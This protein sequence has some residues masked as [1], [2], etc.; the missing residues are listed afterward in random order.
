MPTCSTEIETSTHSGTVGPS[1]NPRLTPL[2]LAKSPKLC[3]RWIILK[4]KTLSHEWRIPLVDSAEKP[5]TNN[6]TPNQQRRRLSL[7]PNLAMSTNLERLPDESKMKVIK[8]LGC[9]SISTRTPQSNPGES[10]IHLASNDNKHVENGAKLETPASTGEKE[11]LRMEGS[12]IF[13][14]S[15]ACSLENLLNVTLFLFE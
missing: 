15:T 3:Q 11:T 14:S 4:Q 2:A 10:Q 7:A 13:L 12:V 9:H 1:A 8:R 5:K 6:I